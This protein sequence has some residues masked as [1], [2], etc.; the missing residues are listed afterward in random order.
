MLRARSAILGEEWQEAG[1]PQLEAQ[2][3]QCIGFVVDEEY[4]GFHSDFGAVWRMS[5][6]S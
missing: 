2:D 6:A 4:L 5:T 3:L 1:L